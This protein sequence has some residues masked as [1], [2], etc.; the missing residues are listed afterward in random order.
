MFKVTVK[1]TPIWI[2]LGRVQKLPFS[3]HCLPVTS[4]WPSNSVDLYAGCNE[5]LC[6]SVR[7]QLLPM[8]AGALKKKQFCF[9]HLAFVCSLPLLWHKH[10]CG[11]A[12][13]LENRPGSKPT[14]SAGLIFKP[15]RFRILIH[16]TSS[17]WAVPVQM[18]RHKDKK[19][20]LREGLLLPAV[21]LAVQLKG[22][23]RLINHEMI[24]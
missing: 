6:L 17:Q 10:C 2:L 21:M 24:Y 23:S 8:L 15:D 14:I 16:Y 9:L 12:I 13:N 5:P 3:T 18:R 22:L 19:E 7:K 1:P 4:L 20:Q 11:H